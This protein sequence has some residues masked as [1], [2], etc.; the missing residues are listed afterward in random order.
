M[1]AHVARLAMASLLVL[2]LGSAA[3]AQDGN[4]PPPLNLEGGTLTIAGMT[5]AGAKTLASKYHQ[6]LSEATDLTDQNGIDEIYVKDEN[7]AIHM[8]YGYYSSLDTKVKR[9]YRGSINGKM[10]EVVHVNNE[11]NTGT[12]GF[13]SSFDDIKSVISPLLTEHFTKTLVGAGVLTAAGIGP[14]L[15]KHAT[16]SGGMRAVLAAAGPTLLRGSIYGAGAM[17]AYVVGKTLWKTFQRLYLE[18][19]KNNLHTISMVTAKTVD[20]LAQP[21]TVGPGQRRE[22]SPREILTETIRR[23][24]NGTNGDGTNGG[25]E[26]PRGENRG[27]MQRSSTGTPPVRAP[28]PPILGAD[29]SDAYSDLPRTR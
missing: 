4:T 22:G 16:L 23:S 5:F 19:A 7:G 28:G 11:L 29:P 3:V 10:V 12:E 13:F 25:T 9:G 6:S 26:P 14:T 20:E 1:P 21:A 18:H 8:V 17:A 24:G 27:G 15:L 2:S